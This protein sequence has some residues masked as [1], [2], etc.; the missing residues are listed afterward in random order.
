M[1]GH[2]FSTVKKLLSKAQDNY[3]RYIVT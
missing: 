1:A 2:S 3:L